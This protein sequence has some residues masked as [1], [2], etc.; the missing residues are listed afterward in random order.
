[1]PRTLAYD[2]GI[3]WLHQR[4]SDEDLRGHAGHRNLRRRVGNGGD[5][6]GLVRVEQVD[7]YGIGRIDG[8]TIAQ[9]LGG[10]G[11][12]EDDKDLFV[13]EDAGVGKQ[14]RAAGGVPAIVVHTTAQRLVEAAVV[15]ELGDKLKQ[16][17]GFVEVVAE[18]W[19]LFELAVEHV[20]TIVWI[21]SA[22]E[23]LLRTIVEAG[24]APRGVEKLQRDGQAVG[25][26]VGTARTE[27]ARI[28]VIVQERDESIPGVR[29]VVGGNRVVMVFYLLGVARGAGEDGIDGVIERVVQRGIQLGRAATHRA[30]IG[31]HQRLVAVEYFAEHEEI[32]FADG[33]GILVDLRAPVL[34]E[35]IVHVLHRIDAEAVKVARADPIL[36]DIGHVGADVVRLSG[37][38][39][40]AGQFS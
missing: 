2:D 13:A 21:R 20:L 15:I 35:T 3:E 1:M 23:R 9:R 31:P 26:I 32:R 11:G 29:V 25:V 34:P 10:T 12:V 8:R 30:R 16:R 17:M 39:V 33:G 6:D 40:Q 5:D 14:A 37:K 28:I 38:I 22:V 24:N 4:L 19:A 7:E 36:V 27:E 18:R